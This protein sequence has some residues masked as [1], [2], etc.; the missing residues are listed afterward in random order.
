MHTI[1]TIFK[2][3][4]CMISFMR[5]EEYLNWAPEEIIIGI[6]DEKGV[7]LSTEHIERL[8]GFDVDCLFGIITQPSVFYFK[9]C[10]APPNTCIL[11]WL[12]KRRAR[13]SFPGFQLMFYSIHYYISSHWSNRV[14][15]DN[16]CFYRK[17]EGDVK[18]WINEHK[19]ISENQR[20]STTDNKHY[21]MENVEVS[22]NI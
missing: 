2:N 10:G 8:N 9:C 1:Q 14:Y 7:P 21:N 22:L 4:T 11:Q 5:N 12:C 3:V 19:I 13:T 20:E 16:A 6:G 15:H 18:G 17:L